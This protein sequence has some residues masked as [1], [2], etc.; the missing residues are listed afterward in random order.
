MSRQTVCRMLE[1]EPGVLRL[2]ERGLNRVR[3]TLRVPESVAK[4]I[5]QKW[6][7]K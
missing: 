6:T 1:N 3:I 7:V 4:R 2:G 5:I